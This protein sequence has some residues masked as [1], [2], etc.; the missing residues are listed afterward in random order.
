MHRQL[1]KMQMASRREKN[2]LSSLIKG[3]KTK[4]DVYFNLSGKRFKICMTVNVEGTSICDSH[5]KSA[6]FSCL[7]CPS[8]PQLQKK[9]KEEGLL[10][11]A[12]GCNKHEL[13]SQNRDGKLDTWA[14]K[15]RRPCWLGWAR[16]AMSLRAD[17]WVDP[18]CRGVH[19]TFGGGKEGIPFV[20]GIPDSELIMHSLISPVNGLNASLIWFCQQSLPEWL[21]NNRLQAMKICVDIPIIHNWGLL[22]VLHRINS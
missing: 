9:K 16:R 18:G 6:A 7:I 19:S 10:G 8:S 3:M 2:S 14:S 20:W 21:W 15:K 13:A 11:A 4:H 17:L 12:S 1:S 5:R 22:R